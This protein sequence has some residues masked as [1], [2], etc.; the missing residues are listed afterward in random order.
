VGR[1]IV[2]RIFSAI[3]VIFLVTLIAFFTMKLVPGDPAMLIAGMDATAE[4]VAEVR[5]QLGLDRPVLIQLLA[6]YG[7]LARGDLGDSFLLGRSVTTAIVERLPVTLS[8]S[9]FALILTVII[10][11]ASGVIAALR[12][13]TWVDQ[14]LMSFALLGVSLPNFWLGLL[15]IILFAV[16]LDLLPSG[17]YVPLSENPWGWFKHTVLPSVSLALAQMGLLARI[18]RSTMLEVMRQDYIRTAQAKGLRRWQIV[19]KHALKNVMIPVVT[20]IGIIFSLLLGG[21]I[22]IETIY[23]VPGV[24]RLIGSAIMRR[25]Y[26]VIQGGLLFIA[27]M[28]VVINLI[29]DVLYA[30]F[31]PRVRYER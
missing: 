27:G 16:H 31:D 22:V 5:K 26:P 10:A 15:L 11:I 12:Q 1:Y 21:S 3:P 30:Y 18:T 28:L 7:D 19:V 6:W 14:T 9:V 2:R 29:V 17:G 8:I 24:G 4:E 13:N 25:D 23:S 20:V